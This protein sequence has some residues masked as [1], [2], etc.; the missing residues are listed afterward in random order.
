MEIFVTRKIPKPGLDLLK[1]HHTLTIYPKQTPPTKQEIISGLQGKQGLLC[2]LT[3]PIDKEVILSNPQLKMIAN[4]AVGYNNID[5]Q[6]ATTQ[7]IPVSNTPGVLTDATAELTWALIFSVARRIIEGDHFT[8]AHKFKGWAPLLM[9]GQELT[10][11]TLGIIGAGRIGTAVALQ[12]QGFNM[13]ILYT[14]PKPN[15]LLETQIHAKHV[16]LPTLLKES[17]VISIHVPLKDSTY[18][19]IS[20]EEFAIMKNT[21]ILINTSR[22]PIVDENALAHALQHN[23]IFGAGLDVYEHEPQI[24]KEL[25]TLD[26]IVLQPHIGSATI[27][28]RTN[29]ALLAAKNMLA[30][31]DGKQPPN[32][33][34]PELFIL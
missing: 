8:R 24:S 11:K 26:N 4:Y 7:K 13:K 12:S 31:L 21:A 17:D 10:G 1:K 22:G 33:V 30:G 19:L 5:I 34:N 3:D 9:L 27:E 2:L 14:N 18:H 6:T 20:T 15:Q 23:E 29:M 25:L 32:C 16:T 28:T